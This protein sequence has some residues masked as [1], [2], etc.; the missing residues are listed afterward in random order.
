ML[1]SLYKSLLKYSPKKYIQQGIPLPQHSVFRSPSLACGKGYH[2]FISITQVAAHL[3][4]KVGTIIDK[5]VSLVLVLLLIRSAV[6][7]Y[8]RP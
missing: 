7:N 1:P 3:Q 8:S 5:G 4:E 2:H 6:S